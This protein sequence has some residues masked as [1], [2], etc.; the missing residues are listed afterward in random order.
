[1]RSGFK[2]LFIIFALG[3]LINLWSGEQ[4]FAEPGDLILQNGQ[5]ILD[6]KIGYRTHGTLN[7]DKSN[8]ILF[9]TWFSGTSEQLA[10]QIGPDKLVDSTKFFVI[11]VDALG[12]GIS[13]SPSN[14][15]KQAGVNFPE[16]TIQD[17]VESQYILLT[18]H[19]GI[20]HL[21][22]VIGISMGR[23]QTFQWI[24]AY[25]EFMTKAVPIVGTPTQTP[26]DLLLWNTQLQ[27]IQFAQKSQANLNDAMRLVGGVHGLALSTPA[28][29]NS[30]TTHSGFFDFYENEVKS[31][32]THDANN[33]ACQ[34]K[35]MM[36]HHIFK[37]FQDDPVKTAQN[38]KAKLLIVI[39]Q[40]DMMV[41]PEPA[42]AF[43]RAINCNVIE[44]FSDSG[45][46]APGVEGF[47]CMPAVRQFLEK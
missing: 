1:M 38:V 40:K 35:A 30:R 22:A 29:V 26:Y 8:A 31:Y 42:R 9:P 19:F 25:P 2:I 10:G 27:I 45:H 15:K 36:S 3:T 5:K 33:W 20:T 12:N 23:M 17:M 18:R 39:A 16:I 21:H 44:L 7:A 11:T 24:T 4:Q 46:L 13:S 37:P 43:A 47:L 34:L 14:S 6:C 41:N 32:S 28:E